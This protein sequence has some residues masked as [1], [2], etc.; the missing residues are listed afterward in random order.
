[1]AKVR[2]QFILDSAKIRRARRVLGAA[3]DTET[4]DEALSI[5]IANAEIAAVHKKVAGRCRMK[6]MDQ[7]RFE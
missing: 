1:M 5:V 7:S 3:T 6:D 4:V 2:K